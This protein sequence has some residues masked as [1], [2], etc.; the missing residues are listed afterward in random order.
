MENIYSRTELLV[1]KENLNKI[2]KARVC[3]FGVGGVGGYALECLVRAGVGKITIVDFDKISISNINRQLIAM[4]NNVGK[5]KVDEYKTRIAEINSDI[6][7]NAIK[8]KLTAENIE[9]FDL[10]N[11]DY[12]L[13]AI[14]DTNAKVALA[15]YATENNIKIISAMGSGNRS[16][17]PNFKIV[18]A[19]KTEG[20]GLARKMR[21]LLKKAGVKKLDC[22]FSSEQANAKAS[23]I[24]ASISYYPAAAGVVMA[25]FVINKIMEQN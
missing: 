5:F 2:K 3:V 17:V 21:G 23:N 4:Q 7:V 25:G 18:D 9:S 14:D 16:G 24:V 20:D 11:F 12:I 8:Q 10:K 19:F 22:V 1:G 15:K 13:D 6:E